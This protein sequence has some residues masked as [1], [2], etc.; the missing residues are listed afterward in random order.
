[1]TG[2]Q[3]TARHGKLLPLSFLS[4]TSMSAPRCSPLQQS[5]IEA[6]GFDPS[7]SSNSFRKFISALPAVLLGT[8]G[9]IKMLWLYY[10]LFSSERITKPGPS[11]SGSVP[12]ICICFC[13]PRDRQWRLSFPLSPSFRSTVLLRSSPWSSEVKVLDFFVLYLLHN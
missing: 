3:C 4:H 6:S 8:L 13:K 2:R 1:M 5:V 11:A 7:F 9:T 10:L 12:S